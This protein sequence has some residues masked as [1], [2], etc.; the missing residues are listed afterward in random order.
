MRR[1]IPALLASIGFLATFALRSWHADLWH[2]SEATEHAIV[3][4][5]RQHTAVRELTAQ[6]QT[7]IP[8]T[9]PAV[10]SADAPHFLSERDREESHSARMR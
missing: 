5:A 8:P 7:P 1:I 9:R 4:P 3:S 2:F 6:R 10:R